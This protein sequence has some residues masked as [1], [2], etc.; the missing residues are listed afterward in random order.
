MDSALMHQYCTYHDSK[1]YQWK[2][3]MAGPQ[4]RG[5]PVL[6]RT[7]HWIILETAIRH[8]QLRFPGLFTPMRFAIH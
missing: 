2:S 7:S 1:G 4:Q 3:V 8:A 6:T 5:N